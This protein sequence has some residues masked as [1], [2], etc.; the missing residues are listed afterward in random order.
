MVEEHGRDMCRSFFEIDTAPVSLEYR[1]VMITTNWLLFV[2]FDNGS[3]L[4]MAMDSSGEPVG[5]SFRFHMYLTRLLVH[6][7]MHLRLCTGCPKK[8]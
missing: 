8:T 3:G 2:V 5:K 7:R 6:S 4:F 1:S